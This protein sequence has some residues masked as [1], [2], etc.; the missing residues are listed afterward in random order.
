MAAHVSRS[1]DSVR[2]TLG[3]YEDTWRM[4]GGHWV[5]TERR[6]WTGRLTSRM[7]TDGEALDE[8]NKFNPGVAQ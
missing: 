3:R 6:V 8:L 7:P 1:A 4:F 5:R 2:V